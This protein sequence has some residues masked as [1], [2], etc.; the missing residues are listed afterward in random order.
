MAAEK[1]R[2]MT[3]RFPL[4]AAALL[5]AA[6]SRAG[7]EDMWLRA[8]AI[9]PDGTEIVFSYHGNLFVVP[10]AGGRA[11]QVT[12]DP[13]YDSYPAWSPDGKLI[14]FSSDRLGGFDVFLVSAGGGIPK[15]LTTHSAN[16]YVKAFLPDGRILYSSYYMA[17]AEDG[18]FPGKF[19]Q[20]YSV[21]T[22][23]SRPKLFSSYNMTSISANAAGLLLFQDEKGY[24]DPWR[25]HHTSPV[26]RDIWLTQTDAEKRTFRRL[27][28]FKG[29]DRNPC[30]APDGKSFYYLEESSGS[31]NV[32]RRGIDGADARRLTSFRR[33]P[34][35]YLSA[36][37]S[38]TLCFSYDGA[39]YTM[40]EGGEPERVDVRVAADE[41]AVP[42]I[43]MTLT[44]GLSSFSL[45]KDEKQVAF[46]ARGDVYVTSPDYETTKRVTNTAEEEKTVSISPD[47]KTIVYD[48]ER[49]GVW[50]I[51][52]ATLARE[53][54]ETFVYGNELREEPLIAGGEACYMPEFSP[55]GK[56]IAYWANRTELRVYSLES[57]ISRTVLAKRYNFSYRD[58]DLSFEWSPDSRWLLTSYIGVG[59]WNNRDVAAVKADGTKVVNLTESGYSDGGAHWALGGKAVIFAS[60]RAGMR[61]H[62]SW[63]AQDDLWLVFLDGEAYDRFRL[64]KEGRELYDARKKRL[65][66]LKKKEKDGK[67]GKGGDGG[68]QPKDKKEKRKDED[69]TSGKDGE[70][71]KDSTEV[72]EPD[73]GGC[74][75]RLVRLTA[76]SGSIGDFHLAEDGRKVYYIASYDGSA[77]LWVRDLDDGSLKVL[78]KGAGYG[79][80]LPA[81]DGKSLYKSGD[82][83]LRKISLDNG[84]AKDVGFRAQFDYKPLA[85]REYI[86]DHVVNLIKNKFYREDLGGVDWDYYAK[87]YRR[88][89][90]E[91]NNDY[92]FGEL[93]SELLGEL[94]ASHTGA[95]V[96]A[97]S[98]NRQTASL[99][100]FYDE[101]FDGDGLL[102]K[103]IVKGGPLDFAGSKIKPGHIIKKIDGE[104]VEKGKDYFPLLAGKSGARTTLLVSDGKGRNEYEEVV[105]PVSAGAVNGL[106]YK[107]WVERRREI[108]EKYSGG[109]VGYVHVKAM[110][111]GS[112]R[113]VFSDVLG[114]YRNK[115]ALVVDIRHNGGGWLHDDLGILLSGKLFQT[116][117]PRGQYIGSDPYMQWY[118]PSAVLICEDDYSNA[119]GFPFMYKELGIGK[120]VGAPV[121]GTMTAVWWETQVNSRIV[122]GLP[123]VAFKDL[124]GNYL[125]NQEL[126]PDILVYQTPEERLQDNDVQLEKAINTLLGK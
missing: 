70:A 51:Y 79:T 34:V 47:G 16:E 49:N 123:E 80:F 24:E 25:K 105:I 95:R 88:F 30:W 103:E 113:D 21:D 19:Q 66:E 72:F 41:T 61:S 115:E 15:R 54:D 101:S 71:G 75:D 44:Q 23:G 56:Y 68:K 17:D 37:A 48:S 63:G 76:N 116:Y 93:L 52:K 122:V 7:G 62:G 1:L 31:M 112:F 6:A 10:S 117:E 98:A 4:A 110:D 91:I 109:R 121:A 28:D 120:L 59:G 53:D 33:H 69:K 107:R 57:K 102:I 3:R 18:V 64:D 90:P 5:L 124:R 96:S 111:S 106:L 11:R 26:T 86:F 32:C 38:G 42:V 40:R 20:V 73:F 94:N 78:N 60:D 118:K 97:T 92:D 74:R 50:G 89:L 126:R 65:E 45:P 87:T 9:S 14:A 12:S 29:E 2:D 8:S 43:P 85:E 99:G 77:D 58:F 82:G 67:D 27:T 22:A 104:A 100:A 55:D 81:A 114:R 35:R 46:V 108:T 13:G 119:H 36:S 84:Q 125:E 39:L 83:R